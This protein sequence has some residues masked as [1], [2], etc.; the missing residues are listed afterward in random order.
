MVDANQVFNR[1]E[2]CGA[3]ASTRRWAASGTKPLPPQ[4][5]RL[6][7]T[8]ALVCI[9]TGENLS[10]ICVRGPDCAARRGRGAARQPARRRCDRW[11]E[12]AA[13][14]D[15]YGLE[16]ASHGGSNTISICCWPCRMPST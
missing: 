15:G 16:L 1:N 6:H 5:M 3:V 12:I 13:I 10:Q 9:A 4:E 11:M 14:A 2:A 8:G 7:G